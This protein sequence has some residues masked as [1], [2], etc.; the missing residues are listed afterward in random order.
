MGGGRS[1]LAPVFR[2]VGD[3]SNFRAQA[4]TLTLEGQKDLRIE[5]A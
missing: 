5:L 4:A 1:A 2:F 3:W